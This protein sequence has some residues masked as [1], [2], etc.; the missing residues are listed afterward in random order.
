V[1][2]HLFETLFP[3]C[4][5]SSDEN[6]TTLET[7]SLPTE[8]YWLEASG[9]ISEDKIRWAIAG[10]RPFNTAGK[11]GIFPT[12]L[13]NG[14]EVLINPLQKIFTACLAFGYIPK[15]WRKVKVIFIPKPC[16]DSYEMA[17]AF[18]PGMPSH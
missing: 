13:K 2:D 7:A 11:D 12:L 9:I 10:F 17:K 16:R 1:A 15:P 3:G 6:S 4:E 8:T 14:I 18:R 5:R